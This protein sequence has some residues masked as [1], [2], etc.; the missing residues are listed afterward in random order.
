L[1]L[2]LTGCAS[3][4]VLGPLRPWTFSSL[5]RHSWSIAEDRLWEKRPGMR[6]IDGGGDILILNHGWHFIRALGQRVR[7]LRKAGGYSQGDKISFGF[8]ARHCYEIK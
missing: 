3:L 1:S 6:L 5:R 7:K 8:S 2:D 4:A